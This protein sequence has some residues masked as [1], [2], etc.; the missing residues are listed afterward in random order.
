MYIV[1]EQFGGA[2]YAIICCNEDGQI[3]LYETNEDADR[4]AKEECQ[5]GVVVD[6]NP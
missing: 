5:D 2:E 4:Y 3:L 1:I 6:L